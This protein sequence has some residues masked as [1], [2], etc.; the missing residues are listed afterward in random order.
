MSGRRKQA[1]A[2]VE[3]EDAESLY[4][5]VADELETSGIEPLISLAVNTADLPAFDDLPED[6][7]TFFVRV[8]R[9]LYE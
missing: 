7:R 1:A 8:M 3:L 2:A 6:T 5:S 9:R 4:E